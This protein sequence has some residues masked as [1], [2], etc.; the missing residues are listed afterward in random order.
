ME[1]ED[2]NAES[3]EPLWRAIAL[4][5]RREI[6]R[7]LAHD[8]KLKKT[9][10]GKALVPK[11][12][13]LKDYV[14]ASLSVLDL[15]VG[16]KSMKKLSKAPEFKKEVQ[17]ETKAPE[18]ASKI[19]TL[20]EEIKRL[21]TELNT[22]QNSRR[23]PPQMSGYQP[24]P[25]GQRPFGANPF[26]RNPIQCYYCKGADHTS[27][28]CAKLG[29]DIE[30][31]LVF[32]QGPN[33]YYPNRQPIPTD[34]KESV[35]ELARKYA[36]KDGMTQQ[37][38]KK[39]NSAT[40][41]HNEELPMQM[42]TTSMIEINQWDMW[43]PPVIHCNE[44]D[45]E[46][47]VGF[48]LRR[49]ARL[50]DKSQPTQ[51]RPEEVIKPAESVPKPPPPNQEANKNP[52]A[53][54][55][56]RPSYP[57]AWVEGASDNDSSDGSVIQEPVKSKGKEKEKEKKE[58]E[59]GSKELTGKPTDKAKVGGGLRKK[60]LKQSF[61]LTLE[62]LLLIAPRFIQELHHFAEEESK[63]ILQSQQSGRVNS[64]EFD[65]ELDG[66][67][68]EFHMDDY[69]PLQPLTYACP[70]GFVDVTINGRK[71]KALVDSG[72]E[73]NIMPEEQAIKLQLPTKEVHMRIT[74][75]GGHTSPVVGLAEEV[76]LHIDTQ[77]NKHA[78]FFIVRGKVHTVL[79]RPFLA[80]HKVRLELSQDRGEILSYEVWDGARL[81]IPICAPRIP[82]WQMAPPRRHVMNKCVHQ[83]QLPEYASEEESTSET[84]ASSTGSLN[85]EEPDKSQQTEGLV[86]L[87][88]SQEGIPED[89]PILEEHTWNLTTEDNNSNH[90]EDEEPWTTEA[91]IPTD[92]NDWLEFEVYEPKR[93]KRAFKVNSA[94][95]L[96][97]LDGGFPTQDFLRL[98]P[99]TFP[100]TGG[101]IWEELP[102][103]P[104]GR[105]GFAMLLNDDGLY[106]YLRN[107]EIWSAYWW[108]PPQYRREVYFGSLDASMFMKQ[109]RKWAI[110]QD[111]NAISKQKEEE[112]LVN[113]VRGMV[114]IFGRLTWEGF[115]WSLRQEQK[116][117]G[118][119][120][121]TFWQDWEDC[122]FEC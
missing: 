15:E 40:W 102:G 54:K 45:P 69:K 44:Q 100:P 70:L 46:Y 97:Y 29:E 25:A 59:E 72:S 55:K 120:Y 61:T 60:I 74:G 37:E 82:G 83:L 94:L 38:D 101:G 122:F 114:E 75:I 1:Y 2:I 3:G 49:S 121:A 48:G 67:R 110:S 87:I 47:E 81:C 113:A 23:V 56:R 58:E 19:Q 68:P 92:N 16:G 9:K 103:Y 86:E 8:K 43:S 73:L 10:D 65:E 80:D 76:P 34:G 106:G 91:C 109:H 17:T 4:E 35:C 18:G 119:Q 27:M 62:E 77:N 117:M 108:M 71:V 22:S 36:E 112:F 90:P 42:P 24:P 88:V 30:K 11:L 79:G 14:E 52:A 78:N 28:F 41:T 115:C 99:E 6:A 105:I 116:K 66:Q 21:R 50:G 31:R 33:F 63:T 107:D 51:S 13:Q 111:R 57:G 95:G 26:P 53:P 20:E 84:L 93:K 32:K 85:I 39:T 64:G 7:D 118:D 12:A 89:T 98:Y 96:D 104:A 5:I